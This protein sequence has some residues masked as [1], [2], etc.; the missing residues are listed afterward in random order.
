[1]NENVSDDWERLVATPLGLT[2]SIKSISMGIPRMQPSVKEPNLF[3]LTKPPRNRNG[4]HASL[5]FFR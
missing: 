2:A 1:M 5:P 3:H 4:R